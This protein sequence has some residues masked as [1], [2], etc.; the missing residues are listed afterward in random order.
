MWDDSPWGADYFR[1]KTSRFG[2]L[3]PGTVEGRPP[4]DILSCSQIGCM[5]F[6]IL[7]K[8]SLQFCGGAASIVVN[9]TVIVSYNMSV[10]KSG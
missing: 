5:T 2:Q 4:M 9:K 8:Q 3:F 6:S 7:V 1:L 10:V